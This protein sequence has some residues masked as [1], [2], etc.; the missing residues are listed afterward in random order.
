LPTLKKKQRT[1]ADKTRDQVKAVQAISRASNDREKAVVYG[2]YLAIAVA[3]AK[4]GDAAGAR[5]LFNQAKETATL[6]NKDDNYAK[7]EADQAIAEAQQ[8]KLTP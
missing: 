8:K 6:I 5:K 3:Q 4:A 1:G 2:P 7:T